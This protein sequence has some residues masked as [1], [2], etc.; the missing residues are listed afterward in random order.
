[1]TIVMQ[2]FISGTCC[3]DVN[4]FA[5]Q[6]THNLNFKFT[7]LTS[8]VSKMVQDTAMLTMED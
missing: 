8:Y 1:M 2:H 4:K 7:V 3:V 6:V 5:G